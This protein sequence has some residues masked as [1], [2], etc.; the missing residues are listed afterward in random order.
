MARQLVDFLK[1]AVTK[2]QSLSPE[3]DYA[4]LPENVQQRELK[5]LDTVK[6]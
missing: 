5:L 4:P 1:W 3:L 6:Y 2:G